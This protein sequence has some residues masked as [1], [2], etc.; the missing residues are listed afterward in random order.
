MRNYMLE[1][2]QYH[3]DLETYHFNFYWDKFWNIYR[4]LFLAIEGTNLNAIRIAIA[5]AQKYNFNR[6]IP[7]MYSTALLRAGNIEYYIKYNISVP[8]LTLER[9]N[10][11]DSRKD[12]NT[13]YHYSKYHYLALS[14]FIGEYSNIMEPP[15]KW[16]YHPTY[17]N[18]SCDDYGEYRRE[19]SSHTWAID[20]KNLRTNEEN[21]FDDV[22]SK[23]W[24]SLM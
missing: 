10:E 11:H 15:Y 9:F 3:A 12:V 21:N 4:N 22:S 17:A 1:L 5:A 20:S 18:C 8:M 7:D 19:P 24:C 13:C 6:L 23:L 14:N 2:I 16:A